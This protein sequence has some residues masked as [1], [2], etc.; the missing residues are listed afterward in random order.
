MFTYRQYE[1]MENIKDSLEFDSGTL[2]ATFE[3]DGFFLEI[4]VCGAVKIEYKGV[5][6]K[7]PSKF[8]DELKEIT[9]LG[10]LWDDRNVK[11]I[12]G[13]DTVHV[14]EN[15]WYEVFYGQNERMLDLSDVIDIDGMTPDK[16]LAKCIELRNYFKENNK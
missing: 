2:I 7:L 16:L 12:D 9:R 6:Y 1:D 10:G 14:H 5:N 15:N 13:Y 4:G 11:H 8:P 3:E